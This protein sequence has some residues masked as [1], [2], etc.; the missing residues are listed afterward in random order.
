MSASAAAT[1]ASQ[2]NERRWHTGAPTFGA[3]ATT[4][5]N[6][7][8]DHI[9]AVDLKYADMIVRAINEHLGFSLKELAK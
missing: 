9:C 1:I 4:I 8:G 6:E 5:Y 3:W 7:H 2:P